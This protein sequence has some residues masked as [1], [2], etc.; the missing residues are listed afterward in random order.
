MKIVIPEAVAP[1]F[2]QKGAG[3]LIGEVFIKR[4]LLRVI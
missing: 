1:P 3:L 2:L 4:G